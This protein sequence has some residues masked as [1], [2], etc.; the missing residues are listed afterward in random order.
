MHQ[1]RSLIKTR[2]AQKQGEETALLFESFGFKHGIPTDSDMVF[3]VRCLPNPYWD[4]KLRKYTGQD[5]AIIRFLSQEELVDKMFEDI[6]QFLD[7]WLPEFQNN[8]R[9]YMTVS[10]GCTGGQHRSVYMSERLT[11][12]YR[13]NFANVQLRHRE[14]EE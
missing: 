6:K 11:R 14:L 7:N 13:Q 4:P 9:T 5:P 2:V 1:L 8:N 3:D 12:H 10:I